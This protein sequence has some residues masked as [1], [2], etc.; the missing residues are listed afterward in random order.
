MSRHFVILDSAKEEFKEI[1]QYVK[2]KFGDM[3][4]NEVNHEYKT[5]F[6]LIKSTPQSGSP[7][8]ELKELG[9]NHIQYRLVRQTRIIYE[10]D[11]DFILIHMFISTKRDFIS[12]LMKRLFNQ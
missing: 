3:I 12:H 7:I 8:E 4:W 5:A 10:I 11:G 1:K 9:I 2:R 6:T